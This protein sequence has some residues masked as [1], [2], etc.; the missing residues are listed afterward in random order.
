MDEVQF[1]GYLVMAIITLGG[2]VAVIT[3]ITQPI[4][5]LRVVVQELRDC[6]TTLKNDN[7]I[8][9]RRL[10]EHGKDI[11]ELKLKIV[12]LETRVDMYH[13]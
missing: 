7:A 3:R 1:L 2:F 10:E 11:D 8:Q 12:N 13:P 5:D 6:I 9:N 4:N